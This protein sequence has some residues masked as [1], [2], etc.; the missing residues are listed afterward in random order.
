MI[1]AKDAHRSAQREGGPVLSKR[2]QLHEA[3]YP[4]KP[5]R[6]LI[7]LVLFPFTILRS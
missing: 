4:A 2:Y 6:D 7:Q 5:V 3:L 1:Q